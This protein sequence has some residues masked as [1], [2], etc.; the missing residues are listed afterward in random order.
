MQNK[1]IRIANST[2]NPSKNYLL[3]CEHQPVFTMG[4]SGKENNLL[5]E[6]GLLKQKGI[7]FFRINRGGD[8]TFHGPGQIVGYPILDLESFGL[9][10]KNYIYLLEESIIRCLKEYNIVAGRLD[11]A[12]GV[13]LTS[14]KPN[15][16]RKI[17]AIGVRASRHITM[18]GFAF[19]INTD[20]SYYQYINP[21][22]FVDKGVTSVELES[23]KKQDMDEVKMRLKSALLDLLDKG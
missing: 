15:Q 6:K 4:K 21:C 9:G 10:I 23:G 20:L 11:G 17:A 22:G 3:F 14:D 5:I 1:L 12:T 16:A 7:D 8:I 2:N 19:N 13:W 18:H